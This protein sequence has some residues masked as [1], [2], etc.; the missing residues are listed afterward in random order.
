MISWLAA[1]YILGAELY[2]PFMPGV[3]VNMY[4]QVA[5]DIN[6]TKAA[7]ET[8]I[9]PDT[10]G[11]KSRGEQVIFQIECIVRAID[12]Y[13]VVFKREGKEI[14]D[15]Y[16]VHGSK[17]EDFQKVFS[18]MDSKKEIKQKQILESR[19]KM[20]EVMTR[21]EWKALFSPQG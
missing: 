15:L 10:P 7:V 20:K 16:L 9:P 21:E 14:V 18:K 19:F 11:N 5:I 1:L 8:V 13:N 12:E 4:G 3:T 6:Q 17:L 2:S